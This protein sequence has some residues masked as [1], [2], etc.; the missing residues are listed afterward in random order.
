MD[1]HCTVRQQALVPDDD[2][3]DDVVV[4]IFP[5]VLQCGPA[6]VTLIVS[7]LSPPVSSSLTINWRSELQPAVCRSDGDWSV[8]SL[9]SGNP[10]VIPLTGLQHLHLPTQ[11]CPHGTFLITLQTTCWV[12]VG[13][14]ALWGY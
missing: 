1:I 12:S 6:P 9:I 10:L 7:G 11:P 8:C 4:F 2:D 3:D 13:V 14:W 5:P